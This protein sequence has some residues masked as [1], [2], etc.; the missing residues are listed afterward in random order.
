MALAFL[1][2]LPTNQPNLYD[3][4]GRT[5]SIASLVIRPLLLLLIFLSTGEP[6]VRLSALVVFSVANLDR[7]LLLGNSTD[8][9]YFVFKPP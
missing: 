6:S 1:L 5:S 3:D 7:F 9:S 4:R 8:N 2:P